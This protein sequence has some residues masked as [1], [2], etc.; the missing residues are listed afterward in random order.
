[1]IV[2]S[3]DSQSK[4]VTVFESLLSRQFAGGGRVTKIYGGYNPD[5]K[6][7]HLVRAGAND[8]GCLT[9]V[10]HLVPTSGN[11]LALADGLTGQAWNPNVLQKMGISFGCEARD[12]FSCDPEHG[13]PDFGEELGCSCGDDAHDDSGTPD[14][15]T[16]DV[17][18]QGLGVCITKPPGSASYSYRQLMAP[19]TQ[20]GSE[21]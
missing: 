14:D 10:F 11:R 1:V 21:G 6:K 17:E 5:S 9:E 13:I 18:N 8:V 2:G 15:E 19:G 3:Y 20:V 16:F 12:C 4:H 7:F